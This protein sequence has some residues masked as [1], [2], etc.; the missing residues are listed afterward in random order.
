MI[1]GVLR[2]RLR[3]NDGDRINVLMKGNL[4]REDCVRLRSPFI[5][6]YAWISGRDSCLVGVSCHIPSLVCSRL[7]NGVCIMFKFSN[8]LEMGMTN[9]STKWNAIRIKIK[10]F[11]MNPE[12]PLEKFI[13]FGK[14]E[15]LC[16]KWCTYFQAILD[17]WITHIVFE[18]GHLNTINI[19]KCSN[20]SENS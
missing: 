12:C 9:P 6:P 17:F 15:N 3:D 7:A 8:E 20:N 2:A 5:L 10:I 11:S 14:G 16:Q 1:V 4:D 18:L 19:F 13:I